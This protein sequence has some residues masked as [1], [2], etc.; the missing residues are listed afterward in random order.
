[1]VEALCVVRCSLLCFLLL[2]SSESCGSTGDDKAC[3]VGGEVGD[4]DEVEEECVDCMAVLF[5]IDI[6]L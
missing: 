4:E 6:V 5:S 2:L 3:L 1:M